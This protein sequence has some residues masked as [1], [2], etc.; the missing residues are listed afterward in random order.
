MKDETGDMASERVM[1][2]QRKHIDPLAEAA[3][4]TTQLR[5]DTAKFD[6]AV[7]MGR[8]G[9]DVEQALEY[10]VVEATRWPSGGR[11]RITPDGLMQRSIQDVAIFAANSICRIHTWLRMGGPRD[12]SLIRRW[13]RREGQIVH[14][15]WMVLTRRAGELVALCEHLHIRD[16]T[17][18][19]AREDP[20][21]V[22][23]AVKYQLHGGIDYED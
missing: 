12:D 15:C 17:E 9:T 2:G 5:K 16:C 18:T 4:R 13:C 10:I 7:V 6:W 21:R 1:P 3:A 14:S 8:N 19:C 20:F 23:L 22:A 11:Q